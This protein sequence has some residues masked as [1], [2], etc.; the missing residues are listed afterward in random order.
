M[1]NWEMRI[2]VSLV[3]IRYAQKT[4]ITSPAEIL[5][6]LTSLEPNQKLMMNCPNAVSFPAALSNQ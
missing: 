1:M 6:S 5:S 4:A 3:A 2:C